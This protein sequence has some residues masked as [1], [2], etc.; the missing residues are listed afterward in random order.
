MPLY[1]ATIELAVDGDDVDWL[2][3]VLNY[4]RV[5]IDGASVDSVAPHH[6]NPPDYPDEEWY[7]A[8]PE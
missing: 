6:N 8:N 2:Y 3:E 5:H 4:I 1:K 7:A